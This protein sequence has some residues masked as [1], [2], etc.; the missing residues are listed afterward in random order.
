M[1]EWVSFDIDKF[2]ERAA[3]MEY[4]GGLPRARAEEL[5]ARAQG[6]KLSEIKR[7]LAERAR[8]TP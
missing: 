7:V 4:D 3:I 8:Q 2:E 5:A 6:Y 1:N